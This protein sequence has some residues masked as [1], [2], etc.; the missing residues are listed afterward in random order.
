[1]KINR[2]TFLGEI[3]AFPGAEK[4]LA[5]YKLPCLSCPLAKLEMDKLKIGDI[6]DAY[7]IDAKKLI[8]ELNSIS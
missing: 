2:D 8:K 3:L 1:M 4:I 5:E 7:K 6:C